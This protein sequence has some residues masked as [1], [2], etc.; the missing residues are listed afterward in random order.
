M[1]MLIVNFGHFHVTNPGGYILNYANEDG[2]DWYT[3]R[4]GLTTWETETGDFVDAVFGAFATVDPDGVVI[5]VEYNPSKLVPDDKTILGID[6]DH[7]K[8]EPGMRFKGGKIL[9]S[10]KETL[11]VVGRFE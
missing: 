11:A 6:T 9:P 10:I 2:M 4:A 1:N 5:H 7:R 8:I 3:L